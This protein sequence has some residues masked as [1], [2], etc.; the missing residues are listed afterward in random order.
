MDNTHTSTV[1]EAIRL[2]RLSDDQGTLWNPTG[3]AIGIVAALRRAGVTA[4][5]AAKAARRLGWA[6]D[7]TDDW[8]DL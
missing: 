3:E 8:S 6:S 5:Q 4:T 7:S 1:A 2:M